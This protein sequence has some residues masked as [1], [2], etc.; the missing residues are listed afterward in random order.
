MQIRFAEAV[1]DEL[2]DACDWYDQH[3]ALCVARR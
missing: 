1:N 2:I 3:L